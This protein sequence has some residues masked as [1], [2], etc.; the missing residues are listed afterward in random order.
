MGLETRIIKC[1]ADWTAAGLPLADFLAGRFT[2]RSRGEWLERIASGEITLNGKIVPPE[3]RLELHDSVEYRPG[4]LP[5]P[6]AD[7]AF[8][9]V[10]ED[11]TLLVIDKPGNLCVHP[12]GPFYRNTLWYL[13]TV[14]YGEVHL[15]SRLDRETSGLL[16]AVRSKAAAAKMNRASMMREKEYLAVVHGEFKGRMEA[17][18]FLFQD[19]TSIIR[20]K[21]AFAEALPPGAVKVESAHTVLAAEVPGKRLSVVRAVPV[22]GRMHQIRATLCSLG[23]P[24]AGDKL[25]G[26]DEK[27]YLDFRNDELTEEKRK[28]LIFGRQALHSARLVLEHPET[29]KILEFTSPL[30]PEI[31]PERAAESEI[32]TDGGSL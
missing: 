8:R 28:L 24:V 32:A 14:K 18:G 20:K 5:E 13:L 16:V 2:Y 15:L 6:P 29:G 11:E 25:Y 21:R 31:S 3:T 22:T 26:L 1:S 19:N 4:D 10:H 30:P 12:A 17:R 27:F 23:F 7:T 9:T